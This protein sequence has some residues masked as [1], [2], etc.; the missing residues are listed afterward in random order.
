[1]CKHICATSFAFAALKAGGSV[2]TWGDNDRGG[3]SSNVD[4]QLAVDVQA[5]LRRRDCL[6][7]IEG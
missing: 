7:S 1:M 2:V 3:D 4:A 6:C 5:H